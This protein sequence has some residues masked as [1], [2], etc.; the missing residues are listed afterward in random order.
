MLQLSLPIN[1]HT[2]CRQPNKV[3]SLQLDTKSQGISVGNRFSMSKNWEE[4]FGGRRQGF[5]IAIVDEVS[6]E[7]IKTQNFDTYSS[8]SRYVNLAREIEDLHPGALVMM[9]SSGN[10]V[11][12]FDTRAKSAIRTLGSAYSYSLTA[13]SSWALIG[14]K[15]LAQGRA[16]EHLDHNAAV[17]VS[18]QVKLQPYKRYG[19]R[20]TVMSGG[21]YNGAAASF[22]ID[23]KEIEI[24]SSDGSTIGLNVVV[25]DEKSGKVMETRVFN[26]H[27]EVVADYSPSDAFADFID[28]LPT[29]RIVAIAIRGDAYT[30]LT[31]N[32]RRACEII[33]SKLIGHV[34]I[35]RSWVIIG[36]KN[37]LPGEVAEAV[38]YYSRA[39]ATYYLP[40][41]TVN[42]NASCKISAASSTHWT[43]CASS[44][45]IG[46]Y[47]SVAGNTYPSNRCP[48]Y[49]IIVGVVRENSCQFEQT[50][51]FNTFSSSSEYN[52][53]RTFINGV[54]NGRI[55]VA[56]MS[57]D[58]VR[59]LYSSGRAALESIGSALIRNV[60]NYQAWVIIGRKG[61][62]PGSV[63]EA[64]HPS[65]PYAAAI[66]ATVPLKVPAL[67]AVSSCEDS[68]YPLNCRAGLS[69]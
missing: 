67:P 23:G 18:T 58:G 47:I 31:Q 52:R 5:N 9:S 14:V 42:S 37:A 38:K 50:V 48:G 55:V 1:I 17:H 68:V 39:W 40:V 22:T 46:T 36:S 16:I 29:D 53:L 30:H 6:G 27:A 35:G 19:L 44:G 54:A 12:Y 32:A 8:S 57:Y 59:Y 33:G 20:I 28:A 64:Y 66:S 49:G 13:Y 60:G 34:N 4:V 11:R 2:E 51:R 10:A 56:A 3:I 61:A 63:P 45:Y 21:N 62:A 25:F 69:V 65:W 26:T 15:G 43:G 41:S 24:A 7:M